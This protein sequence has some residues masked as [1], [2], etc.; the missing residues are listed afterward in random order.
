MKLKGE[1]NYTQWKEALENIVTTYGLRR[2]Y[3]DRAPSLLEYV[4][5][6]DDNIDQDKLDIYS[7]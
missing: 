7:V 1:E 2:Y 3:Y 5:E 6:F 4:D